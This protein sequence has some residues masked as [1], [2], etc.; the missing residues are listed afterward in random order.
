METAEDLKQKGNKHFADGDYAAAVESYS[1]AIIRSPTNPVY[2]T[3]RALAHLRLHHPDRTVLDCR[4]AV[5]LDPRNVKGWYLMGQALCEGENPRFSEAIASLRKAYALAIEQRV[6]YAEEIAA[7]YRKARA[8][9]W[10]V[11]DRRR[12]EERSDLYRYLTGMVE[13]DRNRQL[14]Q[15]AAGD[16]ESRQEVNSAADERLSQI[17]ALCGAADEEA[18]RREVPDAFLGKISFEIMTDPVLAPSGITYDRT[19]ILSHLRKIGQWDPLARTPLSE[20][21][22]H[23]NLALK[24]LIEAF[25]EK[26]GWAADY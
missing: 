3:N 15:L 19:E 13:R 23:P 21:D 9:R 10:E 22:L 24:E 4:S 25:L 5:E 6:S 17:A 8:K 16:E 1:H 26:N 18:K 20:S 12:R 7:A 11:G 14:S 2:F